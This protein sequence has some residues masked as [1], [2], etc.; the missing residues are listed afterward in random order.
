MRAIHWF[1]NDLRVADNPAL[2]AA[3]EKDVL[4]V[5]ILDTHDAK[6]LGERQ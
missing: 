3:S 4:P 5:F 2:Y 6:N 1:R